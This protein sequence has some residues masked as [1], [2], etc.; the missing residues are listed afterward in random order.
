MNGLRICAAVLTLCGLTGCAV[1]TY[2]TA[3]SR[4]ICAEWGASLIYPSR[5]DT[6]ETARALELERRIYESQCGG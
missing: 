3:T 5:A 2:D 1:Q 6:A 4:Q